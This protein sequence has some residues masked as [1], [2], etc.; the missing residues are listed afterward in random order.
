MCVLLT[1]L[2]LMLRYPRKPYTLT[3]DYVLRCAQLPAH[4][5]EVRPEVNTHDLELWAMLLNTLLGVL[6]GCGEGFDCDP[7][8][9]KHGNIEPYS[10]EDCNN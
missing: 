7:L 1:H 6:A 2:T 9:F 5:A 3:S 4:A 8:C 10:A